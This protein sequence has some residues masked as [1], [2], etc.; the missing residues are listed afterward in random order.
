MRQIDIIIVQM[1]HHSAKY[2]WTAL[3][4][5]HLRIQVG[6]CRLIL[7]F[8]KQSFVNVILTFRFNGYKHQNYSGRMA[9]LSW[10]RHRD[11]RFYSSQ[12]FIDC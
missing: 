9:Q 6:G 12:F 4:F 8:F 1:Q 3:F 2:L 11:D 7:I 5:S 10:E